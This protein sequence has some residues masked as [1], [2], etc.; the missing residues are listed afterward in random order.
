MGIFKRTLVEVLA[1]GVI[2]LGLGVGANAVRGSGGVTWSRNYFKRIPPDPRLPARESTSAAAGPVDQKTSNAAAESD[3]SPQAY[4]YHA[5]STDQVCEVFNDPKT[6]MG[7]NLFVDARSCEAFDEGHIPGALHCDHY[8]IEEFIDAVMA[9]VAEADKV[10]VYCEGG[11]CEDSLY[12]CADLVELGVSYDAI[13]LYPGGW[14][15]WVDA[16]LPT[17]KGHGEHE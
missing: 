4:P 12:L 3:S 7:A 13:C 5:V 14:Q 16:G 11:S 9:R 8:R 2:G 15:A 10:I 1:L 17:E 6:P